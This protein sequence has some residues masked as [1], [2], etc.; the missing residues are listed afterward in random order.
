MAKKA[1]VL[2]FCLSLQNHYSS[3]GV[4]ELTDVLYHEGLAHSYLTP[5]TSL[6]QM[7]YDYP[8]VSS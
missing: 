5:Q 3:T 6:P 8:P 7:R 4:L 1:L 2:H